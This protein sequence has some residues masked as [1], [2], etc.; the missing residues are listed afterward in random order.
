MS[1]PAAA[2]TSAKPAQDVAAAGRDSDDDEDD[3]PALHHDDDDDGDSTPPDS[4]DDWSDGAEDDDEEEADVPAPC[5][6]CA[7][8]LPTMVEVRAHFRSAHSGFD[9][10]ATARALQLDFYQQLKLINYVRER[11]AAKDDAA[12]LAQLLSS[13]AA[14]RQ[15]PALAFLFDGSD[16]YLKP[17]LAEDPLLFSL[18]R[19]ERE[20][21]E[22][23]DEEDE[24]EAAA[25]AAS[26]GNV[27]TDASSTA[28]SQ[29]SLA[30]LLR[31]NQ[32]LRNEL[33]SMA[34]S[35]ATMQRALKR[36]AFPEEAAAEEQEEQKSASGAAA[37]AGSA[38]GASSGASSSSSSA[39]AKKSGPSAAALA[40]RAAAAAGGNPGSFAPAHV[41]EDYFGGYSG[42]RIH[43]LML[44]DTV[45]TEAY[46]DFIL[47]NPLLFKDKVVLDVGCGTGILSMFAAKAGAKQVIG[48][49]AADI[50][51]QARD[52][53]RANG[54]ADRITIV[55]GKME[56]VVLPVDKVDI[57]ISEWMGY[58]LLFESMLPSV[59][60]ARDKYLRAP[61]TAGVPI[62]QATGVYPDQ[63]IMYVSAIETAA[64]QRERIDWWSDVYG[65]NMSTLVDERER[66][67]GSTVEIIRPNQVMSDQA[68]LQR[69]D[70]GHVQDRALDFVQDFT[71]TISGAPGGAKEGDDAEQ[72]LP[73]MSAFMVYFDTP[74]SL[75]VPAERVVNLSTAPVPD[76][77]PLPELTT[78]WQQSVFHLATPL[79]VRRGDQVQ[80]RMKATRMESNPRAYNVI[81]EWTHC[82]DGKPLGPKNSQEYNV[83]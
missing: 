48:V 34:E 68:V 57:I 53:V 10:R 4:M 65:F 29:A 12:A 50:V 59:L 23:P 36:V 16:S 81:L 41:D 17:V 79:P 37:A 56:E 62:E 6:F 60:Y 55:H 38:A 73:P 15:S 45:R 76:R 67:Q 13:G 7:M 25:A 43:E 35:M 1:A 18:P 83:Q 52:I 49:D 39:V 5:L 78:H 77:S 33:E 74:F 19:H 27:A 42:R 31:E 26:A 14:A 54:F 47:G 46:R 2:S 24:E 64:A 21:G 9:F 82:R 66:F 61:P 51:H 69:F 30:A 32:G 22:E 8:V 40:A 80:A 44:R 3:A 75:H 63:A 28:P 71:L 20:A 11:V 70:C 58:F 72:Q